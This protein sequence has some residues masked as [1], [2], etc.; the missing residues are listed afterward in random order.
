LL[1]E[2]LTAAIPA[3]PLVRYVRCD[4]PPIELCAAWHRAEDSKLLQQFLAILRRRVGAAPVE[5]GPLS[6]SAAS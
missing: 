5:S 3:T 4:C 6:S 2:F 1:P